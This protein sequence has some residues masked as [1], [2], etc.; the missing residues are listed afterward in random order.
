MV[1]ATALASILPGIYSIYISAACQRL[2]RYGKTRSL[3]VLCR[4]CTVAAAGFAADGCPIVGGGL[5]NLFIRRAEPW[6]GHARTNFLALTLYGGRKGWL[7]VGPTTVVRVP[8]AAMPNLRQSRHTHSEQCRGSRS[9]GSRSKGSR[10]R[11]NRS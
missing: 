11:G 3:Y 4:G 6:E 7:A 1:F 5:L 9:R 2:S 8:M 10:S